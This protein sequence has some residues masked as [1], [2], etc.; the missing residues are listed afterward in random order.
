MSLSIFPGGHAGEDHDPEGEQLEVAGEDGG[1]LGVDHVLARQRT[2]HDHLQ[3][4]GYESA[5]LLTRLREG[6]QRADRE[7]HN[8]DLHKH[9]F[10][11]WGNLQMNFTRRWK[12]SSSSN[13]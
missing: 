7:R 5:S 6:S 1:A 12:P 4:E 2:L 10:N 11:V 9:G 8:N 13:E 3:S